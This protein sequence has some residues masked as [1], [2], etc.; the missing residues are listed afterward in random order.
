[1][2]KPAIYIPVGATYT[3][4]EKD[5]TLHTYRCEERP[6]IRFSWKEFRYLSPDD[7]GRFWSKHACGGCAFR[8]KCSTGLQCSSAD[9]SDGKNVWFKLTD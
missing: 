5:G 1:M 6:L 2:K 4:T 8:D 7:K 9:R 3:I